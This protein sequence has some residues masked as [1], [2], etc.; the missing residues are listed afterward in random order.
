MK[1]CLISGWRGSTALALAFA[2]LIGAAGAASAA[3]A[4]RD[5]W[6]SKVHLRFVGGARGR[7]LRHD[8]FITARDRPPPTR[9]RRSIMLPAGPMKR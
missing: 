8:R 2:A 5:K 4:L 7:R 9:A 3:D 1:R 6:C